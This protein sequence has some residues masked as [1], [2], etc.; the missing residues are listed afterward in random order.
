MIINPEKLTSGHIARVLNT[1][2]ALESTTFFKG[3]IQMIALKI[4]EDDILKGVTINTLAKKLDYNCIIC[5]IK[6]EGVT[7]V[8]KGNTKLQ[9]GDKVYVTGTPKHINNFLKFSKRIAEKT[10]KVIISGG[11]D[12]AI[13]LAKSLLDM[14][15]KVKIIELSEERCKFLSAELPDAI[16]INGDVSDQNI[17]L[18]EGIDKCD[19]FVSLNSIDEE[20]II[21]SMFA[22]LQGV[23]KI[24]T[25]I[26]HIEM[27]GIVEKTNLDTVITPHKI[28]TNQI[29]KY[30]R[31]I[32][33]QV[34]VKQYIDL[35]M[36][37]LKY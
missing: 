29:V 25:K 8:P 27:D 10:K 26:N 11:S 37:N 35:K 34:I 18:E 6:R 7:I 5:A 16:I 2:S 19:A 31:A 13:Y 21:Y 15:I 4:K 36:N 3:R 23:P 30:I 17:L 12:T 28:A 9:V 1:P 20:N 14:G 32:V 22:S 33:E 24:I